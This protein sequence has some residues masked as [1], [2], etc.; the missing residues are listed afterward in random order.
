MDVILH[1]LVQDC[2]VEAHIFVPA[3]AMVIPEPVAV[4]ITRSTAQERIPARR[5]HDYILVG[6]H[7]II[8]G[9]LE[10][11]ALGVVIVLHRIGIIRLVLD[12]Y[13]ATVCSIEDIEGDKTVESRFY[14][15]SSGPL[16][17]NESC[18]DRPLYN[19]LKTLHYERCS[20][21]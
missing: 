16:L 14:R 21:G 9:A 7:R 5:T 19:L 11:H 2:F 1:G 8:F 6:E 12:E 18:I 3:R 4:L 15:L 20:S 13:F 10:N 17:K